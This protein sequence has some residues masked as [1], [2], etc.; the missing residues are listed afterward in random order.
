MPE[1][2]A[3]ELPW[4]LR[5]RV[6]KLV[7]QAIVEDR[8]VET[9][10][11]RLARLDE[12]DDLTPYGLRMRAAL[13]LHGGD[14]A[15]AR[16][17]LARA[18]ERR[19][20]DEDAFER[21]IDRL[22]LAETLNELG[23]HDAASAAFTA[24]LD[25]EATAARHHGRAVASEGKGDRA[26]AAAGYQASLSVAEVYDRPAVRLDLARVLEATGDRDGAI[27]VL[28]QRD[29]EWRTPPDELLQ[30]LARLYEAAGR[31]LDAAGVLA[32][33]SHDEPVGDP[34]WL[35]AYPALAALRDDAA[36]RE[37]GVRFVGE[38]HARDGGDALRKHYQGGEGGLHLGTLWTTGL[39]DACR[40]VAAPLTLIAAGPEIP[41]ARV[42]AGLT[43]T[44]R[45]YA[46]LA[47]PEHVWIAPHL[48]FPA[49]LFTQVPG[50]PAA[51]AA[52]IRVLFLD[53]PRRA[54]ELSKVARAFM[55]YLDQLAVP[56]PYSGEMEEAGPHELER[57][58][59]FSPAADPHT[60]GTAYDDDPWPDVWPS[61]PPILLAGISRERRAQRRGA[62]ARITRRTQFSRSHLGF[63][64]H[65]PRGARCYVWHVRY[66]P[67]PYPETIARFNAAA[68]AAYPT[69]LPA[70]VVAAVVG[71]EWM[72]LAE[73]AP[74]LDGDDLDQA[75]AAWKLVAGLRHDELA[76]TGELRRWMA[77]RA[78]DPDQRARLAQLCLDY[79]WRALLEDLALAEPPGELRDMV[80]D[81]LR[82]GLPETTFNEMGEP[83]GL[84]DPPAE[85]ES[86]D[87]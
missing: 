83:E 48:G 38:E 49:A 52:A 7:A 60:W 28:E 34:A 55:G 77:A 51:V 81:V 76:V 21:T 11:A 12:G 64:I 32:Q 31:S 79:G 5:E 36:L 50:E 42:A 70:D 82:R 8:D 59:N 63:E 85:E 37:L 15:A 1:V 3:P 75:I 35:D 72:T 30:Q 87:E 40:G 16:A 20:G 86:G 57:H 58:F 56:N 67:N 73:L 25:E 47:A 84:Y 45:L 33:V 27:A 9:A 24:L 2:D 18:L 23:D 4:F 17:L 78:L 22:M 62:V 61:C 80:L 6:R 19:A 10:R 14:P 53:V 68:G 44:I 43:H 69:D 66:R 74:I 54:Q 26:A 39:W 13:A 29:E 65:Q 71:F 46:D 41:A